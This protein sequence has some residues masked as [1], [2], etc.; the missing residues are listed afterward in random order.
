MENLLKIYHLGLDKYF[1]CIII[2][3]IYIAYLSGATCYLILFQ[4]IEM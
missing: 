2:I 4:I 3:I 1:F